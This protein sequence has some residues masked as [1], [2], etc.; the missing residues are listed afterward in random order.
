MTKKYRVQDQWG[1]DI[2][3]AVE[4]GD[5]GGEMAGCLIALT[6]MLLVGAL[7]A[8]VR[9]VMI[10][11][12][13]LLAQDLRRVWASPTGRARLVLFL[14]LVGVIAVILL[15]PTPMGLT[16]TVL[17]GLD[18]VLYCALEGPCAV[19][20]AKA[21][22][23]LIELAVLVTLGGLALLFVG[24]SVGLQA[25]SVNRGARSLP[26]TCHQ[27]PSARLGRPMTPGTRGQPRPFHRTSASYPH[28]RGFD[29]GARVERPR[30][31]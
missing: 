13:G 5:P 3:E 7:L 2:G 8:L 4:V 16:A 18:E 23:T 11:L 29:S 10:P 6:L 28:R 9:Y 26:G 15:V 21:W 19:S 27:R 22:L 14:S 12:A 20:P 25:P 24:R 30:R 1:R 31:R 17:A